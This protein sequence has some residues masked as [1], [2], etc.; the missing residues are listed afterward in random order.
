MSKIDVSNVYKQ[1]CILI[2]SI[3]KMDTLLFLILLVK[4]TKA[5]IKRDGE[6]NK[7]ANKG[8]HSMLYKHTQS[9]YCHESFY[10]VSLA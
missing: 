10:R 4:M 7:I 6:S 1:K 3:H 9:I 8:C 5:V 2:T